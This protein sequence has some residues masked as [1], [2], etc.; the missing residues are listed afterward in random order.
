MSQKIE[1]GLVHKI[2]STLK[3]PLVSYMNNK[4]GCCWWLWRP[5]TPRLTPI[6]IFHNSSLEWKWPPWVWS[7]LYGLLYHERTLYSQGLM[8][9]VQFNSMYV[10]W[11]AR[12]WNNTSSLL[13]TPSHQGETI[14]L[15]VVGPLWRWYRF[16]NVKHFIDHK[17]KLQILL[18]CFLDG[19]TLVV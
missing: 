18:V 2:I 8:I 3:T 12:A 10:V 4:Q 13:I 11:S 7:L 17:N 14:N 5:E 9:K 19:G 15:C 16:L 1:G 6:I